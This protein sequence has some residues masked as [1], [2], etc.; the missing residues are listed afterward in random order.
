L[1]KIFNNIKSKIRIK[2]QA[3][4]AM[5]RFLQY[6]WDYRDDIIDMEI[7]SV[8]STINPSI[9]NDKISSSF[10]SAAFM[11]LSTKMLGF[12]EETPRRIFILS[13]CISGLLGM[14]AGVFF[15]FIMQLILAYF[16]K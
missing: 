8:P 11:I 6:Y 15:T 12:L 1:A 14:G 9:F 13:M 7:T 16:G 2:M 10:T 5:G 3:S 4:K